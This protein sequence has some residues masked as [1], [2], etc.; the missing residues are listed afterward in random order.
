VVNILCLET[1]G[2]TCSVALS[3]DGKLSAWRENRVP[4]GHASHINLFIEAVLQEAGLG[5]P[6]L[7]AVAVSAGPGSYTGLRI[8]V[9]TAKGI[10]F[11]MDISFI[12]IQTLDVLL[13]AG[14]P[15]LAALAL[16]HARENEYYVS[17]RLP[18]KEPFLYNAVLRSDDSRFGPLTGI[19]TAV[20][21]DKPELASTHFPENNFQWMEAFQLSARQ[22]VPLAYDSFRLGQFADLALFEPNYIKPF[23]LKPPVQP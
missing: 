1:S 12:A 17:A 4:N 9:S 15:E 6:E 19:T 7:A 20:M 3:Q 10:C 11:G 18:G 5:F 8:G 16:I 23:Y 21:A 22:L 14:P 2:S 13:A